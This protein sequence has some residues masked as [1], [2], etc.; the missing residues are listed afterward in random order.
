MAPKRAPV[1]APVTIRKLRERIE[2]LKKDRDQWKR[3]AQKLDIF[4]TAVANKSEQLGEV[5]K[6]FTVVRRLWVGSRSSA[7]QTKPTVLGNLM[8]NT[9]APQVVPLVDAARVPPPASE[10]DGE[11][12]MGD[13]FD[14]GGTD[15]SDE[16]GS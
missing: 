11:G 9:G 12:V 2:V 14:E 15:S 6:I 13:S 10:S 8:R 16:G 3:K 5:K 7:V 4:V 1:A